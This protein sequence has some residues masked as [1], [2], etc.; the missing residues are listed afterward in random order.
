MSMIEE[1]LK[2]GR[3]G[4]CM[5]LVGRRDRRMGGHMNGCMIGCVD[6]WVRV[7]MIVYTNI[8]LCGLDM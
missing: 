2:K 1:S 5:F 8:Q 3:V 7:W 4:V 6:G